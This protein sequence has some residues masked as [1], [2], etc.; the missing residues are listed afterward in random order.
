M[1]IIPYQV[2]ISK[3]KGLEWKNNSCYFDASIQALSTLNDFNE[4]L[5][6]YNPENTPPASTYLNLVNLIKGKFDDK[7]RFLKRE[8][9]IEGEIKLQDFHLGFSRE[10]YRE[11]EPTGQKDAQDFIIKILNDIQTELPD[12]QRNFRHK[13]T[14]RIEA[15][16]FAGDE[17]SELIRA[18]ISRLPNPFKRMD[19]NILSTT[20]CQTCQNFSQNQELIRILPLSFESDKSIEIEELLKTNFKNIF[21]K[22]NCDV[23]KES[24][25]K[26][27]GVAEQVKRIVSLPKYLIISLSRAL[28]DRK[29]KA[30]V[31]FG[32]N[33]Y[34]DRIKDL[35]NDDLKKELSENSLRYSLIAFIVHGGKTVNRGHYWAYAK[36][37]EP[38]DKDFWYLYN[39]EVVSDM[40]NEKGLK[41][42][43]PL[44]KVIKS[45]LDNHFSNYPEATPYI[46]FYELKKVDIQEMLIEL[47]SK[48]QELKTKLQILQSKMNELRRKLRR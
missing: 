37:S 38:A 41:S 10:L 8:H 39:D 14:Q 29:I 2:L 32:F 36:S 12:I 35:L 19:F 11:S 40:G 30:S 5:Q 20:V 27:S 15:L 7:D 34:L 25:V 23:C 17:L 18:E 46:L 1:V 3:N 21:L 42:D 9:K 16:G 4:D 28:P 48:L 44:A 45:G 31:K 6:K 33:L 43:S 13:L 24:G 22:Y 47:K 26:E